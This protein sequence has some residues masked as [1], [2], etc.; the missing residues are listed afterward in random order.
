MIFRLINYE[1]LFVRITWNYKST[2]IWK[3]RVSLSPAETSELIP[4]VHLTAGTKNPRTITK[5]SLKF[6]A[7]GMK[8]ADFGDY[9]ETTVG[10]HPL[11][12][13]FL[14]TANY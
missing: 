4:L 11:L 5:A 2:R 1:V 7:D 13:V 14:N 12:P 3:F 10:T 6:G 9:I 8:V